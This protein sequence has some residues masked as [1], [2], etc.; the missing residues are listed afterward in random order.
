[1][2]V[3]WYKSWRSITEEVI[4][5]LNQK[6]KVIKNLYLKE[7]FLLFVGEKIKYSYLFQMK[8]S[9]FR[10][11]YV[12]H[13]FFLELFERYLYWK[14]YWGNK[15]SNWF[16]ILRTGAFRN[17]RSFL[18]ISY[19]AFLGAV[20]ADHFQKYKIFISNWK[21]IFAKYFFSY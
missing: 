18:Q 14:Y 10:R 19:Y 3:T 5:L 16:L 20:C 15:N 12:Q 6:L 17:W 9:I 11:K 8:K 4:I 13:M 2:G 21:A 7:E 1:M